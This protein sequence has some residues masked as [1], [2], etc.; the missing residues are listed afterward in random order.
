MWRAARSRATTDGIPFT[1]RVEDIVIPTRCP[2]FGVKLQRA[3]N[4]ATGNSPSL[5]RIINSRGYVPTNIWVISRRANSIKNDTTIEEL[6]QLVG[7][8]R[9]RNE[10]H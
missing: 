4:R 5:D 6:E 8:L 7:A 10:Q 2:V 9:R 1:I 3:R